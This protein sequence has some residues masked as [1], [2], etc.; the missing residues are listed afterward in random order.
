[1]NAIALEQL[2]LLPLVHAKDFFLSHL[3]LKN[4]VP[5][6]IAGGLEQYFDIQKLTR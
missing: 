4:Y 6:E 5:S 2:P 3:W 1:M